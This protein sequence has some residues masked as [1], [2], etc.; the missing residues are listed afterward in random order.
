MLSIFKFVGTR[1]KRAP[2]EAR[3]AVKVQLGP[4]PVELV[5]EIFK[6]AKR[7]GDSKVIKIEVKEQP[8]INQN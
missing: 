7:N 5:N 3:L 6:E 1:C 2:E 8:V 4:S